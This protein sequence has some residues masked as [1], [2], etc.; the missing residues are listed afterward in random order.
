MR[1]VTALAMA[2]L[3]S[4]CSQSEFSS[5]KTVR[6]S[7]P[8]A[9]VLPTEEGEDVIRKTPEPAVPGALPSS[10][11]NTSRSQR[12]NPPAT[13]TPLFGTIPGWSCPDF[14]EGIIV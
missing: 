4:H 3:M 7:Q 8:V 10:L 12:P 11:P 13:T 2:I 6:R 1:V 5:K 14:V 9:A